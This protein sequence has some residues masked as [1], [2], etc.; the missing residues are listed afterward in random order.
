[1]DAASVVTDRP[2]AGTLPLPDARARRVVRSVFAGTL[3]LLALWVARSYLVALVWA[4]VIAI[5]VWP[6][7]AR[8]ATRLGRHRMLLPLV[9]T[10]MTAFVLAIPFTLVTVQVG[11]QGQMIIEWITHAQ[12]S[13]I[14][15]PGWLGR[16]PVLGQN[17][18]QW[19]RENLANPGSA[20]EMLGALDR[21]A[22]SS[23]LQTFGGEFLHRAF[24]SILTFMALFVLLRDGDSISNRIL[25]LADRWLG[26]P[27]ERLA[28]KMV[29]VV[30]GTVNGTVL[31]AL[32]EGALI[33]I[34]YYLA[35]VPQPVLFSILTAAVAMLPFGAWAAFTAAA[36]ILL[37][38]GSAVAAATLFGWGAAVMLAG[39]NIV[40]PALIGSAARLPFLAV[41]IGIFG[42]LEAFGLVG[43]FVGPVI[44]A[45]LLTVWRE[46]MPQAAGRTQEDGDR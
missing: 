46:W 2:A 45:A 14:A 34:G 11:R 16:L 43:L 32:G 13:G 20:G 31:V 12:Q 6:L 5:S 3:V 15:V 36:I 8:F 30:R 29:S 23:W 25:D 39:D 21:D 33:G 38:Q 44:M 17:L 1:M 26:N 41:L 40:Q 19:W 18:E 4:A 24:L 37:G 42:G 7:Y 27:G 35:G 28:E 9:F 22:L 10:V